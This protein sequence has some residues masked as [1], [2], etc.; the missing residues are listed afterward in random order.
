M[1]YQYSCQAH[2]TFERREPITAEHRADCPQCQ[3]PAQR[4][5]SLGGWTWDNALFAKDGSYKDK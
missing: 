5:Y 2:G 1:T 4:V 3:R